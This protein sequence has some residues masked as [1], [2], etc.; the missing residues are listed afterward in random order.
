M[1]H[2]KIGA[3]HLDASSPRDTETSG[4]SDFA[5]ACLHDAARL[6]LSTFLSVDTSYQQHEIT[7]TFCVERVVRL[8]CGP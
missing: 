8:T 4:L 5:I 6:F 1:M 2:E 3:Q 7:V